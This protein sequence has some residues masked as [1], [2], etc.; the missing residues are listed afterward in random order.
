MTVPALSASLLNQTL[1]LGALRLRNR[2][3]VAPMSGVSDLPF[4]RLALAGA[5]SRQESR[6]RLQ[7]GEE[8]DGCPPAVVQ[9]IGHEP[10]AMAEAARIAAANGAQMID[11][12]MGCPAKKLAGQAA[13]G[14]TAC[15]AALMRDEILA[16]RVIEAV[17]AAAALPVSVKMRLGWD[18]TALTA[19]GLARR[20]EQAGVKMIIVHARTR[21]QFYQGQADWAAVR[22]VREQITVPLIVNGDIVSRNEAEQAMALSG[23]DG[24]MIGRASY[25]QPWL[26]GT[27]AGHEPPANIAAYSAAHYRAM[28][29]YYGRPRGVRHAR[30]HLDWY[31]QKH[32]A[33]YYSPAERAEILASLDPAFVETR[34]AAIFAR[35]E[36]N[37]A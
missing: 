20:A 32:V 11:I 35:A 28:L 31:L 14:E 24:V 34:L 1:Q 7:N 26:A 6:R 21:Q 12:N 19:P 13:G 15:G 16:L 5:G 37:K 9:L 10:P 36:S 23:A 8:E 2:V 18:E 22:A 4:R 27:I 29:A 33:G 3:F 17:M 25:G 30:K